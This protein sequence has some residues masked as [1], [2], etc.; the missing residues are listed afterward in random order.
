MSSR[1]ELNNRLFSIWSPY[2]ERVCLLVD[3]FLRS[4]VRSTFR[5]DASTAT[6]EKGNVY[7]IT[8]LYTYLFI[9]YLQNLLMHSVD[10]LRVGPHC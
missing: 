6:M 5:A 8:I 7:L 10:P 3:F 2:L 9:I 1:R 4:Y